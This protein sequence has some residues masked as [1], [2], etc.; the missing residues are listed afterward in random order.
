MLLE[1]GDIDLAKLLQKHEEARKRS[2]CASGGIDD[3]FLRL[4]WQQMLQVSSRYNAM[5]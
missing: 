5:K 3:N 1:F 2:G 4:Y